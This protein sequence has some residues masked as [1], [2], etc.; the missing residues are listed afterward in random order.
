MEH[1]WGTYTC[2]SLP[3]RGALTAEWGFTK[4][5]LR[6]FWLCCLGNCIHQGLLDTWKCQTLLNGCRS[7]THRSLGGSGWRDSLGFQHV[8]PTVTVR[9]M[10]KQKEHIYFTGCNCSTRTPSQSL[11][12]IA[13][14]V[15]QVFPTGGELYQHIPPPNTALV[16]RGVTILPCTGCILWV[17]Q[18]AEHTFH[19]TS[20]LLADEL[21]LTSDV[22]I[23]KGLLKIRQEGNTQSS[24]FFWVCVSQASN[25]HLCFYK[26]AEETCFP[27]LF[28]PVLFIFVCSI[29]FLGTQPVYT[30]NPVIPAL[31]IQGAF[32]IQSPTSGTGIQQANEQPCFTSGQWDPVLAGIGQEA[33]PFEI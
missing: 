6:L 9:S 24:P 12:V 8:Y 14:W 32:E 21:E 13:P 28:M 2:C 1:P 11:A 23:S 29:V 33:S 7:E 22:K 5:T 26:W 25:T 17:P 18:P 4:A 15:F 27:I 31:M 16:L 30:W 19:V 3:W 20:A 10:C